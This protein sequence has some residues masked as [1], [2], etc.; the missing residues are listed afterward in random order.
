MSF[1]TLNIVCSICS[2]ITKACFSEHSQLPPKSFRPAR[3]ETNVVCV[4]VHICPVMKNMLTIPTFG[5]YW[6]LCVHAT[7]LQFLKPNW[8][9]PDRRSFCIFWIHN[10]WIS[11]PFCSWYCCLPSVSSCVSHSQMFCFV[12]TC[13]ILGSFIRIGQF[14]NSCSCSVYLVLYQQSE[15][16][17]FCLF[18]VFFIGITCI[19]L[20]PGAPTLCQPEAKRSL[21]LRFGVTQI[22]WLAPWWA[23]PFSVAQFSKG[24]GTLV[25]LSTV[26]SNFLW[27]EC[28]CVIVLKLKCYICFVDYVFK[29]DLFYSTIADWS[30]LHQPVC[31]KFLSAFGVCRFTEKEHK[32][33]CLSR[34]VAAWR[35]MLLVLYGC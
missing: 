28:S 22:M 27:S 7:I 31:V 4:F 6:S 21:W 20:K 25:A 14:H 23:D 1:I 5:T 24:W 30:A 33:L 18:F 15:E 13:T 8:T 35:S 29:Y 3:L 34:T 32:M 26:D 11:R 16:H 12:G 9:A 17:L 19:P 2:C 10:P